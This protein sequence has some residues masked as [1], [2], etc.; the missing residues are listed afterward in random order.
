MNIIEYYLWLGVML[1]SICLIVLPL[2]YGVYD[3]FSDSSKANRHYYRKIIHNGNTKH[4]RKKL[5]IKWLRE[6][7]ST[8]VKNANKRRDRNI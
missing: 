8:R 1:V 3:Y 7:K 4:Q 2:V 6:N 5:I